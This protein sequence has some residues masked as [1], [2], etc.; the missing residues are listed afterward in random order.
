[1]S[2]NCVKGL[3]MG[4]H[5]APFAIRYRAAQPSVAQKRMNGRV[6]KGGQHAV[7]FPEYHGAIAA[8]GVIDRIR[9]LDKVGRVGRLM[10]HA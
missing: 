4:R 5:R 3:Q 2:F 6:I 1:M 8:C 10:Q 9:I 7:V